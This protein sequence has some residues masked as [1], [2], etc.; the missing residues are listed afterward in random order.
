MCRSD[1]QMPHS[2]TSTSTSPGPG[3]GEGTSWTAILP[4]PTYTAAD[5]QADDTPATIRSSC[6]VCTGWRGTAV[7]PTRENPA[8]VVARSGT[9]ASTGGDRAPGIHRRATESAKR[10]PGVLRGLGGGGRGLRLGGAGL[11]ALHPPHGRGRLAGAGVA[12]RVRRPSARAH[13][14][15]DL[16]RGVAL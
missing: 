10:A 14:P 3:A 13:R 9:S 7:R 11:H 5:M 4:S 2:A 8:T 1:P 6:A 15:D 12:G 16:R